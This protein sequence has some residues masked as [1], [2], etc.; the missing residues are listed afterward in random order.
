MGVVRRVL[1]LQDFDPRP[2][3]LQDLLPLNTE[4]YRIRVI[5]GGIRRQFGSVWQKVLL[6]WPGY[7]A[8][9]AAGYWQSRSTDVIVS[10]H[11][12]IGLFFAAFKRL[13]QRRRPALV[14]IGYIYAERRGWIG[15][16]R[17]CFFR[18]ASQAIDKAVVGS[19]VEVETYTQQ[20][21]LPKDLFVSIPP[22][23]YSMPVT[24][25]GPESL[26]RADSGTLDTTISAS[27]DQ[28]ASP[29]VLAAGRSLRDYQTFVEAIRGLN[30]R[31]VIIAAPFNVRG[32]DL[33]EN[34]TLCENVF[35][36]AF[37][38][39]VSRATVVVV[40]VITADVAAGQMVVLQAMAARRPVIASDTPCLREY[41]RSGDNGLLVPLRDPE[42]LREAIEHL[43]ADEAERERLAQNGFATWQ[44]EFTTEAYARKL[45]T[46]VDQLPLAVDIHVPFKVP[47][48]AD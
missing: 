12:A 24:L 1:L 3:G 47:L 2:G 30:I 41:I 20:L 32:L 38:D 9:A 7:V 8:L 16:L 36:S 45:A 33:P 46:V 39:M 34:V 14:V 42:A 23:M 44:A 25:S 27:I 43:L 18:W 13:F 15:Y 17:K 28:D 22:S 6:V 31:V 5:G 48:T 19:A 29:Y 11:G 21:G 35:G 10:R 40:P 26:P 4:R 37:D